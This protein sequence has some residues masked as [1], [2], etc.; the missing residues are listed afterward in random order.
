MGTYSLKRAVFQY[1]FFLKQLSTLLLSLHDKNAD[2]EVLQPVTVLF[3]LASHML[4]TVLLFP[5][6]PPDL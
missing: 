3:Q 2:T 4:L 6:L 1:Y 5:S